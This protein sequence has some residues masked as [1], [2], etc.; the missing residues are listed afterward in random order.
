MWRTGDFVVRSVGAMLVRGKFE[1]V[2]RLHEVGRMDL[3]MTRA[4]GKGSNA[5][6]T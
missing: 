1:S 6:G 2:K 4:L 5:A 3:G